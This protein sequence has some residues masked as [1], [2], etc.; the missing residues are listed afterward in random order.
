MDDSPLNAPSHPLITATK[1]L[2]SAL[3]RLEY[4]LRQAQSPEPQEAQQQLLFFS[5]ENEALRQERESLNRAIS[6]LQFQ[7]NDLQKVASAIYG[8]LD[9]SV[10]KLSQIIEN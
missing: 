6:Q 7:Y 10:K 3:D 9:D 4:K 5:Q 1:R 8:K 2:V